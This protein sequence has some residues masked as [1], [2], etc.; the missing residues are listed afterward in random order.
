MIVFPV[1][2][3]GPLLSMQLIWLRMKTLSLSLMLAVNLSAKQSRPT[4]A[5]IPPDLGGGG[6][7]LGGGPGGKGLAGRG[8]C[9]PSCG[10]TT[11]F[12]GRAC[13][14]GRGRCLLG[15]TPLTS[16]LNRGLG[17]AADDFGIGTGGC[18]LGNGC[19]LGA[20]NRWIAGFCKE[21]VCKIAKT[22][23]NIFSL[24]LTK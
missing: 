5:R 12:L 18:L 14:W 19:L 7:L 2:S 11:L 16:G 22:K 4:L 23:K 8:A 24:T 3:Q 10:G 9:L 21:Y 17:G 6:R 13:C 15:G 20:G 1:S